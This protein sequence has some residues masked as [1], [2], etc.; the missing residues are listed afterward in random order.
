ME[1]RLQR[2]ESFPARGSDGTL[3]TV[4][5][6]ERM[7]RTENFVDAEEHWEPTGVA[8]YKLSTGERVQVQQDGSMMVP[9]KGVRL[10]REHQQG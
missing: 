3:Y 1:T 7:A 5:G 4:Y 6:Y 8:E 2:L 9:G 10:E